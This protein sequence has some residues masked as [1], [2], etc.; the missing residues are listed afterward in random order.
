MVLIAWGRRRRQWGWSDGINQ[1]ACL[2]CPRLGERCL[3]LLVCFFSSVPFSYRPWFLLTVSK[4]G[5]KAF[6][7][8]TFSFSHFLMAGINCFVDGCWRTPFDSLLF[9]FFQ[10]RELI[11]GLYNTAY[12]SD[13]LKERTFCLN[14]SS[15]WPGNKISTLQYPIFQSRMQHFFSRVPHQV[16]LCVISRAFFSSSAHKKGY[17]LSKAMLFLTRS[18][19]AKAFLGVDLLTF[20]TLQKCKAW[21]STKYIR[22]K[23]HVLGIFHR[24]LIS[25][26]C[27]HA[28]QL[29]T[30]AALYVLA[31]KWTPN[32]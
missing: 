26:I 9:F 27:I 15:S 1:L 30:P 6:V 21:N 10:L 23:V 19:Y 25:A 2:L 13:V 17:M 4:L 18:M 24:P 29:H 22:P 32:F 31:W 12:L 14:R 7:D 16:I 28:A 20:S 5:L 3:D 8:C 11:H